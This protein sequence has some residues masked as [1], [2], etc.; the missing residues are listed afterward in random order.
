LAS[1]VRNVARKT[2]RLWRAVVPSILLL[3]MLSASLSSALGSNVVAIEEVT[4]SPDGE[5]VVVPIT[6]EHATGIGGMGIKLS[7]DPGVVNVT[8]ATMGDFTAFFG[9]DNTNAANGWITINTYIM[10]QDL[11]GDVKVADVTL[12]AVGNAGDFSALDLAIVSIADQ[13]GIDI[14]GTTD[15]GV[16]IISSLSK[17]GGGTNNGWITTPH[18]TS[19]PPIIP[20]P[21]P[22]ITPMSTPPITPTPTPSTNVP[23][24]PSTSGFTSNLS[25]PLNTSTP[26]TPGF[27]ALLALAGILVVSSWSLWRNKGKF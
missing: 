12:E 27:K 3:V 8:D 21:T 9:F 4:V 15:K 16:F 24:S 25:T 23:E 26:Q 2:N 10:G 19:T 13:Y 18:P 7:Y 1:A 14:D 20:T 22:S 6:I 11:T 5:V 17:E